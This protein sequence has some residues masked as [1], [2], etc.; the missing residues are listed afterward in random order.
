M[1]KPYSKSAKSKMVSGAGGDLG[2]SIAQGANLETLRYQN[3]AALKNQFDNDAE[4]FS[5]M[6]NIFSTPGDRPRGI[7][8]NFGAG[9]MKGLAYGARSQSIGQRKDQFD[10]YADS[11]GYMQEVQRDLID[12]N[13]RHAEAEEE[14][15]SIRPYAVAGLEIS[16]SGMPYEQG[17]Q[18]MRNLVEQVKLNNP[19]VKGDYVG[20]VPNTPIVNLRDE[21][22]NITA[23][24]LSS[25]AGEDIVQRVQDGYINQQKIGNERTELGLKYPNVNSENKY[26]S[27][28]INVLGGKGLTPF[29]QTINA[30][31]NLA[32]DIP[33]ILHQLDEAERII[34]G[35]KHLGSS[36]ANVAGKSDYLKA[37]WLRGKT[38]EDYEAVDKIA[39]R[40]A[41]AFIRAK[42]SAISDSERENI[43]KGL[44]QVTNS[45]KGN[46]Y[47][48][49]SLRQEVKIAFER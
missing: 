23:F 15:A 22:G 40:V 35:N 27:I 20:Y 31:T 5:D 18:S 6:A 26:G 41:E 45:E 9:A 2:T 29:M 44:F 1:S 34:K 36:W 21:N 47:N 16:Y 48:I 43:M 30:E 24:S 46:E 3:E 32:K 25:I 13:Q 4:L 11:I 12:R 17:N 33:I 19:N 39:K 14:L 49:N 28:P 7:A 37:A 42:G 8:A 38:R 10:K